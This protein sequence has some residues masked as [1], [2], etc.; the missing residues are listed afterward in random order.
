MRCPTA[1]TTPALGLFPIFDSLTLHPP[2]RSPHAPSLPYACWV[3]T[4]RLHTRFVYTVLEASPIAASRYSLLA[5]RYSSGHPTPPLLLP[6]FRC[7]GNG[8]RVPDSSAVLSF[9]LLALPLPPTTPSP[10]AASA[11]V[12][13]SVP[14]VILRRCC[15]GCLEHVFPSPSSFVSRASLCGAV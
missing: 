15:F 5:T 6:L 9:Y 1:A 12:V 11:P 3:V 13:S 14:L 2:P 4:F 7:G 8:A 10:F